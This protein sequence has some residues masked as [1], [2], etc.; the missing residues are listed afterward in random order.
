M[1]SIKTPRSVDRVIV[2]S[3]IKMMTMKILR[4]L[5]VLLSSELAISSSAGPCLVLAPHSDD[6]ALGCAGLILRLRAAGRRVVVAIVS[7][8]GACALAQFRS[9]QDVIALRR[10]ESRA[11]CAM[12]GVAA[13]D[14]IFMGLPDG[15]LLSRS[16]ELVERLSVLVKGV[17]PSSVIAPYGGD[18]HPDHRAVANAVR[19]LVRSG[20]LRAEVFEYPVWLPTRQ[21]LRLAVS[22]HFRSALRTIPMAGLV[23]TKRAAIAQYRSQLADGDGL[24]STGVLHDAFIARFVGN[25]EIFFGPGRVV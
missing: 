16:A 15:E 18:N 11:G 10:E 8:G 1:D 5:W 22:R 2:A 20:Q 7:D 25:D 19:S 4:S 9:R 17:A 23:A 12:L 13:E 6:E 3:I 21:A 24:Q 14:V